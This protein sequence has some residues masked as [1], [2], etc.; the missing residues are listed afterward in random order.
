MPLLRPL[1]AFS[2]ALVLAGAPA[3]EVEA[4]RVSVGVGPFGG[5]RVRTPYYSFDRPAGPFYRGPRRRAF[6]PGYFGPP[7]RTRVEVRVGGAT[8][9]P[10]QATPPTQ[11]GR[12]RLLAELDATYAA[13][14]AR[15][16]Q[17]QR[18]E[19]WQR[20]FALPESAGDRTAAYA[21]L[22]PRFDSVAANPE[23]RVIS[24][25]DEFAAMHELLRA[26]AG[27]SGSDAGPGANPAPSPND[28]GA[29]AEALPA[30]EASAAPSGD[31]PGERSVL[32]IPE[33]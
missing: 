14:D 3:P 33:L 27:P 22:L 16:A 30:P 17:F 10:G 25:L 13:L 9:G 11:W 29:P 28:A 8:T 23:Y 15:L 18:G 4:Q 26:L 31:G 24:E 12:S 7:R 32:A 21:Q 5:V 6:Y 19:G 20:Y 2:A 1:V